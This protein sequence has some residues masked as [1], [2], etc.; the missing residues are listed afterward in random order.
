MEPKRCCKTCHHSRD[1]MSV[2]VYQ[3]RRHAPVVPLV[4]TISGYESSERKGIWPRVQE[5]DWCGDWEQ[6]EQD[7]K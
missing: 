4:I 7:G 2:E 5:N 1:T 6:K 3:C